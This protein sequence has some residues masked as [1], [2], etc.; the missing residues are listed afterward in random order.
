MNS[1]G[2][3][4]WKGNEYINKGRKKKKSNKCLI[5]VERWK[6]AVWYS[7]PGKNTNNDAWI[8]WAA[9]M[10]TPFPRLTLMERKRTIQN[11]Q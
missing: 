9:R 7:K 8:G 10:A 6:K 2:K 4:F 5:I 3:F 11:Q 1:I